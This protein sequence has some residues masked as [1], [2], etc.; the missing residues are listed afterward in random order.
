MYS[1]IFWGGGAELLRLQA[2]SNHTNTTQS[3]PSVERCLDL[4]SVVIW[5]MTIA[6]WQESGRPVTMVVHGPS[7]NGN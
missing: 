6:S 2:V 7:A 4:G 3:D 1:F 5:N